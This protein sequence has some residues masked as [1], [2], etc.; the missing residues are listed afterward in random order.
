MGLL[1]YRYLSNPELPTLVMDINM[2][3]KNQSIYSCKYLLILTD[4]SVHGINV[5]NVPCYGVS[6][7][8]LREFCDLIG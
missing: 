2:V 1:K 4:S 6:V 5:K 8:I 3:N 7:K